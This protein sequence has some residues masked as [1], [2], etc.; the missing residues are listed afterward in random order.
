V[1][2][3]GTREQ[4]AETEKLNRRDDH[5]SN[6]ARK[7]TK[8]LLDRVSSINLVDAMMRRSEWRESSDTDERKP[9]TNYQ[10]CAILR[11]ELERTSSPHVYYTDKAV[12]MQWWSKQSNYGGKRDVHRVGGG[13]SPIG[14]GL[15]G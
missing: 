10:S 3:L 12:H 5:R 4:A 14:E 1:Q 6:R 11:R 13:V 7:G 2:K 8:Q 9:S 15:K